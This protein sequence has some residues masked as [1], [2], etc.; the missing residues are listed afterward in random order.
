MKDKQNTY[1]VHDITTNAI[2]NKDTINDL[3]K[4]MM[5]VTPYIII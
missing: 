2:N 3:R 1:S 4:V 5:S